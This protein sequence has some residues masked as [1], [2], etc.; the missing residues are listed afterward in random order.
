MPTIY[1][2]AK[3]ASVS[4]YTVSSVINRSAFVSP[5]LTK[6]VLKAV[7]EL[8]YT[9]N[10]LARGL[11]TRKTRTVAMLIPD[12]GSPFYSRVVRG[13]ENRLRQADY[14]LM[15]GN[16]YNQ[17]EEQARYLTV[18]RS[19]QVDGI[20]MF[21]AAGDE[22]EAERMVK[23]KKA[24]VFVGRT[25]R[26]FQGDSV[27]ADN[28]KGTR[29]AIDHLIATGH[30]KIAIIT[31]HASLSTSAD[32]VDGW[33]KS[34]RRAKLAAP[35]AMIGEG[36][37]TADSGCAVA[38]RLLALSPR[39]TAIFAANF[40]MMT[41]VL[42][43]LKEGG[44]RCPEDVQVVSSDDSE[45]LDVFSPSITTVAQPSFAMG[46]HAADL[47]LKRMQQPSRKF[48]TIVLTPELH[49]RP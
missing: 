38:K 37:W 1:D 15:L 46:E 18:F 24:V 49:V 27:T 21:L 48:E 4:T 44:L 22:S 33:R 31:G 3:R 25:P 36:D 39:P 35:A 6:R 20:L 28:V 8:D 34:M 32:R 40:P 9:P 42:R 16:T 45:W 17:A 5:E 41:G 13:V 30:Q 10:A 2:V 26:T 14:S 47:L 11:Q 29:L 12:I 7:R 19:Q 43:A 23:A